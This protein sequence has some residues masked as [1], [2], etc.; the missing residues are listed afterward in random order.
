MSVLS[1]LVIRTDGRSWRTAEFD[2]TAHH[3]T[4]STSLIYC[5]DAGIQLDGLRD[6]GIGLSLV[7]ETAAAHGGTLTARTRP[8]GGSLF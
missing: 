5:T 6:D 4:V 3:A 2:E 1:W 8:G 7:H